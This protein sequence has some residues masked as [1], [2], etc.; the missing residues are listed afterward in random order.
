MDV[1]ADDLERSVLTEEQ[2][3]RVQ[4]LV[5]RGV[6]EPVA[7]NIVLRTRMEPTASARALHKFA[8]DFVHFTSPQL[9]SFSMHVITARHADFNVVTWRLDRQVWVGPCSARLTCFESRC[10]L[11][12]PLAHWLRSNLA[13]DSISL[14]SY[15]LADGMAQA[16]SRWYP[17]HLIALSGRRED[18]EV[19]Q[20]SVPPFAINEMP[21]GLWRH[22]DNVMPPSGYL[23]RSE[24]LAMVV[25]HPRRVGPRTFRCFASSTCGRLA[26]SVTLDHS[27]PDIDS[28]CQDMRLLYVRDY[29]VQVPEFLYTRRRDQPDSDL[30][31]IAL[32]DVTT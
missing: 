23:P 25:G 21:R 19:V 16:L 3:V 4:A 18:I 22:S 24:Y 28:A 1:L 14:E 20:P 2:L 17:A 7:L 11:L 30:E 10:P 15:D 5:Q 8:H 27:A 6:I 13:S 26:F 29:G 31:S 32:S 9:G 12:S